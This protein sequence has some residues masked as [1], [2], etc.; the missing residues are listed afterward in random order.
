M[1]TRFKTIEYAWDNV[2]TATSETSVYTSGDISVYIP[3]TASRVFKFVLLELT[4]HDNE[5][6][7]A[8]DISNINIGLSCNGGTNWTDRNSATTMADTGENMSFIVKADVT[9]EFIAR[10][11]GTS[12]TTTRFRVQFDYSST[13]NQYL[14]IGAKLIITY[15][16]DD[17]G[18]TTKIK[19]VRIPFQGNTTRLTN[20]LADI[21]GTGS[22]IPPLNT[23]LP[24]SSKVYRDIF[25]ETWCNT[26]PSAASATTLNLTLG[27]ETEISS[28]STS[29]TAQSPNLIRLLWKRSDLTT[30]GSQAHVIKA[31]HTTASQNHM[32]NL[33]GW[34]TV[35]YEY[36]ESTTGSVLNSLFFGFGEEDGPVQVSTAMNRYSKR[37]WIEEPNPITLVDSAVIAYAIPGTTS[38]TLNL[39]VGSGTGSQA[40]TAYTSNAQTGQAGMQ[41]VSHSF[42]SGY[43]KPAGSGFTLSRGHNEF[44]LNWYSG[45]AS[46]H[47]NFSAATILNYISGIQPGGSVETHN[48]TV[49]YLGSPCIDTQRGAPAVKYTWTGSYDIPETNWFING[50]TYVL[51]TNNAGTA[52][53]ITF[54]VKAASTDA[55]NVGIESVFANDQLATS[56]RLPI[57][58][59]GLGRKVFFRYPTDPD[60][61]RFNPETARTHIYESLLAG[62]LGVHTFITYH[63]INYTIS[64]SVGSYSGTG[65]GIPVYAYRS[66]NREMIGSTITTTGGAYSILWYD[67]VGSVFTEAY[68]SGSRVGRSADGGAA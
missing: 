42:G 62:P 21:G 44:F 58:L 59:F 39:A 29:G 52:N 40:N 66:D 60:T 8:D 19:T 4:A 11:S 54:S 34:L 30:F 53:G 43:A 32:S 48:K 20:S 65:S 51:D 27:S 64:G 16:Y 49:M 17:A 67:N 35:T 55:R 26:Q 25:F 50:F 47:S 1:A 31:R 36:D 38:T 37:L 18:V 22:Q 33:G 2:A 3:E 7:V 9:A 45:A 13:G 57:R 6:T 10:F 56:E 24:E 12:N 68:E 15:S 5:G 23:Y 14:N 46:R 63:G 61:D 41:F 28:G